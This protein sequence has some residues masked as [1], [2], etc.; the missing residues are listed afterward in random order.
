MR[1][2]TA[3]ALP[4]TPLAARIRDAAE[5]MR[6][7][8]LDHAAHPAEGAE[9]EVAKLT[10][11]PASCIERYGAA[12]F[13]GPEARSPAPRCQHFNAMPSRLAVATTGPL[14]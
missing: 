8:N 12:A 5:A 11:V 13:D 4:L 9:L 7:A 10:S 3:R 2:A 6:A 14:A 1:E